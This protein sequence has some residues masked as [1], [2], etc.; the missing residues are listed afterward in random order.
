MKIRA[1][2]VFAAAALLTAPA[3]A[4]LTAG[5]VRRIIKNAVT[6]AVKISPNSVIAV[7]DREGNVL[8]V[9]VV[10]GG[11]ATGPEI[12]TAVS[13]AGTAAYLSSN[14]NAFTSRTAGFIIQQHFP[15]GVN[16]A[17]PGPLV[18]V[19][20]S[21][22]FISDINKFRGPGS[23]IVFNQEPARSVVPVPGTS[24][25]GTPGGVPLYKKGKLVGG[26]G[27]TGDGVPGP[28][29]NFRAE[30]PFIFIAG[31]DKDE[32]IALAGQRRFAPDSS[33]TADNVFINGI[34]LP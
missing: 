28:I 17:A 18:G 32:D 7:T 24:L 13:K 19:G 6:R 34:R 10:G 1:L 21:N 2:L 12:A 8:A 3:S 29:P 25:D 33:I 4:Q 30:N 22:L 16:Y 20:L 31:P 15:P 14:Q 9:W 23:V 26:I 27:V 5:N 11:A